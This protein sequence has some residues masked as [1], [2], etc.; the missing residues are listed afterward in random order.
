MAPDT[1]EP[2]PGSGESAG[3]AL[4]RRFQE[5]YRV[6]R[7]ARRRGLD[8]A[9]EPEIRPARD[10]AERVERFVGV[11]GLAQRL[12][13]LQGSGMAR[14]AAALRIAQEIAAGGLG[15][16]G[17]DPLVRVEAAVRSALAILTEGVVAAPLD[18]IAGVKEGRN[19]NGTSYLRVLFAGPIRSAG[20]TEQALCILAADVARREIGLD[21]YRARPEEVGRYVEEVVLYKELRNLQYTPTVEEIRTAVL[22]C[23]VCIDGE[24]TE[25]QE[26]SRGRDLPRVDTNRVRGGMALVLADGLIAKAPKLH[27][28]LDSE[29]FA[30]LADAGEWS[31]LQQVGPRRTADPAVEA[32]DPGPSDKYLLEMAA[33]RPVLSHPSAPGGF[34]LRYGRARNTGLATVGIH[35]ATMVL[36]DG[37]VAAGTQLKIERPGKGACAAPVDSIEGPWVRLKGGDFLPLR[38][39]EEARALRDQVERII[40][41]GE[42]LIG[43]GEFLENN[44]P[45]LPGA[46]AEE[47]W[48]LEM[49]ERKVP[50]PALSTAAEALR[51]ARETGTPLH[52]RWTYLWHDL[53][54]EEF[55][56]LAGFVKER[57]RLEE[58]SLILPAEPEMKELLE[59]LLVEHRVRESRL[60][61]PE[62]EVLLACLG[63]SES[64]WREVSA[65]DTAEGL[66]LAQSASG[67]ALR[68]RAPT[69]IGLRVGRPEKA[70]PRKMEPPVHVLFP[71]GEAGGRSRLVQEA[72]ARG[73][74]EVELGWRRCRRC[75]RDTLFPL[76]CGEETELRG[77]CPRCGFSAA[78]DRCPRC[79]AQRREGVEMVFGEKRRVDVAALY[80]KAVERLGNGGPGPEDVSPFGERAKAKGGPN[81]VQKLKGVQGLISRTKT[82][83]PLEKGILRARHGITI[84][85]DGTARYDM[86]NLPL[87]HFTP[88]EIGTP[89]DR[90]REMGYTRDVRGEPLT[91][92]DQ[93]VEL[94]PQDVVLSDLGDGDDPPC[95]EYLL[96]TARFVD[97]LLVR[98]YGLEPFYRARTPADLVGHLVIGLAPHTSAGVLGRIIGFVPK[99]AGLAHPFFHAAKRRNC[100]GDEDA[101]ILLLDGLL[102]FSRAYLP[103]RRGGSMDAPLV[104]SLR[105]DPREIDDEAHNLDAGLRYPL[106]FYRAA[107]RFSPPAAV[108]ASME[109]VAHRL[110]T[111]RESSGL[112]FTHP[113]AS[114]RAGPAR[115]AYTELGTMR[116]KLRAELELEERIR[117]VDATD[118]AERVLNSHLLRDLQGNLRQFGVQRFRCVQ[119][120]DK[121]RRAPLAGR[122]LRCGGNIMFTTHPAFIRKYLDLSLEIAERYGVSDYTKQR[123]RLLGGYI[124]RLFPAAGDEPE[125]ASAAAP[126]G[127]NGG[128]RSLGDFL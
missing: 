98:F 72:A 19:E 71:L 125:A 7:E 31:W 107:E 59:R 49:E 4:D 122:C 81:G 25:E 55:R 16:P 121:Y 126:A 73:S 64:G 47:V 63:W 83:E 62:P 22:H 77:A 93:T 105:I 23:P 24:P 11:P 12:R 104:L 3:S 1:E 89:V 41:V 30:L 33:G 48:R 114:L 100:D 90:L 32:R 74:V 95:S 50:V 34:R 117:A 123:L 52:P 37:F 70:R 120:N 78:A 44:H 8:P 66:S 17:R 84:F 87:T 127:E 76:C 29:D 69:R 39:E 109:L 36:V 20:G 2:A 53:S 118:V 51:F 18:G 101:V 86:T 119:C 112:G 108:Q 14:E 85:K 115:S 43:Y 56:R 124:E 67:L 54:G 92:E 97:D 61:I 111:S 128:Q 79:E 106:E 42:V 35:P 82:P 40:D 58:G 75:S 5:A 6:A 15:E 60:R 13:E 28:K 113:T 103:E 9:L 96:R 45:L 26:V 110:S 46:Y 94:H 27:R 38:T 68:R 65:A 88:R 116:D 10:L 102:N 57:G 99:A 21:R 80:R 91:S